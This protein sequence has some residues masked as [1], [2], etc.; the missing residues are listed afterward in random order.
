ME[1]DQVEAG[2]SLRLP[3]DVDPVAEFVTP[4]MSAAST[5]NN[6]LLRSLTAYQSDWLSFVSRRMRENLEVP[7]RLA[8]CHTFPELQKVYLDYWKTAAE[9]YSVEVEHLS[10]LARRPTVAAA[11]PDAPATSSAPTAMPSVRCRPA[12]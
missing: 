7:T 6:R 8:N 9:Q 10:Q 11:E 12:A 1:Y 4:A 3:P 2:S 5:F